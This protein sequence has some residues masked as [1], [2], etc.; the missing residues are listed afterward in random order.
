MWPRIPGK[1]LAE[2]FSVTGCDIV[3]AEELANSKCVRFVEAR[4]EDLPFEDGTFD[5][6]ICVKLLEHVRD[7]DDVL[8]ELRRVA[9]KRI[10]IVLPVERP[11]RFAFNLHLHCFPYRF[12]VLAAIAKKKRRD[13]V[14]LRRVRNEWFYVEEKKQR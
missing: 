6:V 13:E 12:S 3:R 14:N 2:K 4:A 1:S 7:I 8:S 9:S 11:Y 10:I 5:T